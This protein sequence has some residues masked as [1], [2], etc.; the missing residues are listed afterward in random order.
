MPTKNVN[1]KV[2]TDTKQAQKGFEKLEGNVTRLGSAIGLAFGTAQLISFTKEVIS[3]AASAEGVETAFN[4]LNRPDLLQNLRD[5]T[6]GTISDIDLMKKAMI[7]SNF[8]IPLDTLTKGLEFA[9]KRA[10]QTGESV[11]YLAHSFVTGLGRKSAVVL[12]NLGISL[13]EIQEE[14][15]KIGDFGIAVGNIMERELE[16][17]GDIALTTADKISQLNAFWANTKKILGDIAI[18]TIVLAIATTVSGAGMTGIGAISAQIIAIEQLNKA[19]RKVRDD[20]NKGSDDIITTTEK[21]SERLG[22]L[23]LMYG[24]YVEAIRLAQAERIKL[25]LEGFGQ[26]SGKIKVGTPFELEGKRQGNQ[27]TPFILSESELREAFREF[28]VI[29]NESARTLYH[30][31]GQ[32]WDDIFGKANSLFEQLLQNISMGLF[33]LFAQDVSTTIFE[34][35]IPGGGIIDAIFGKRA[36]G[37]SVLVQIGENQLE[38][39]TT[40]TIPNT[41]G[42]LQRRR[43]L[44]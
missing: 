4:R 13:S 25:G 30:A 5:A 35:L 27:P 2:T 10:S 21:E 34:S 17:M 29:A 23:T 19:Y 28:D 7:A 15:A 44:D 36:E 41:L 16:R 37:G 20:F 43:V 33:D 42:D 40:K 11:E 31:F 1:L 9:Q 32:A 14:V 12:D 39:A 6:R 22:I 18:D 24:N 26:Q 3:I 38:K 8:K